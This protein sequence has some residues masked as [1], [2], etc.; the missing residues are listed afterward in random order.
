MR[1]RARV[2]ALT[3]I[4]A[5]ALSHQQP[6]GAAPADSASAE[7]YFAPSGPLARWRLTPYADL[8]ILAE[9]VEDRPG[10]GEPLERQHARVR[11]GLD[12]GP[13]GG[14]PI[15]TRLGVRASLGSDRNDEARAA[16]ANEASD[17]VEID[18]A[19]VRVTT[20][21]GH[22]LA[23]GKMAL[24]LAVSELLWDMDLRPVG[25]AL[26]LPF[27]TGGTRVALAGALATRERFVATDPLARF[28]Q[29]EATL[30][31]RGGTR[32]ECVATWFDALN[33]DDLPSQGYARQNETV[34]AVGRRRYA[35]DFRVADLQIAV[36]TR[37]R[38][39]PILVRL[40]AARNTAANRDRDALRARTVVGGDP[41][42]AGLEA[43]WVH[44]RI[45]RQALCGA[46][47][48]DD[49]WFHSRTRGNLFWVAA[50][51]GRAVGA[52][53]SAFV[54]RRDDLGSDTRRYRAEVIARLP[55]R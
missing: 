9:R 16:F 31:T 20:P 23:L 41:M 13:Y 55:A 2:V 4:A 43:G 10:T 36:A 39:L 30:E 32:F 18:Q 7:Q 50:G 27:A 45:E 49:W 11:A 19:T 14:W 8:R 46:F 25:A 33:L 12:G 29:A 35:V 17:T 47:N 3:A 22:R 24:P 52:R 37:W 38:S 40:E 51:V 1:P 5:A 26:R 6:A 15:E 42:V 28:A 48:S 53:V 44:Q 21:G 34:V 54:E